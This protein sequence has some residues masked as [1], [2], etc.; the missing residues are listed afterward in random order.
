[1]GNHRRVGEALLELQD[2]P[3]RALFVAANN[4]AVTCP[5]VLKVRA[6]LAREDLFTVVH[7]PFLSLT[8]R[9]ADIVLPATTYLETEDLYRAYGTYWLQYGRRAVEPQGQA[10]SNF[11]LAQALARRMGL[12]DALFGMSQQEILEL[13]FRGRGGT[14]AAIDP[15]TLRDAGPINIAPAAEGQEFRTPSGK[16]EFY[17]AAL[18]AEGLGLPDWRPDPEDEA[19]AARWKLR[20][21]TVPGYFQA[22]TAYAGVPFLR[23][24]EGA[25]IA[26][27]HP[28]D[29]RSRGLA[30]S[31]KIK[32]FNDPGSIGL[33]LHVRHPVQQCV[34]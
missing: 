16:L 34:I 6:G 5:E 12:K 3:I 18:N 33:V 20:L 7:D 2:P 19:E 15:A 26:I 24:R 17:S 27:L 25:P 29:A 9:Y 31:Q 28:Q 14:T 10:W 30:E 1:M 13:M 11:D 4:P 8:G 32:L 21:L 22:H 23:K